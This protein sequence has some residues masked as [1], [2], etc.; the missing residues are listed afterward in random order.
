M[1]TKIEKHNKIDLLKTEFKA[2]LGKIE[3][4]Q[5]WLKA[6]ML[7]VLGLLIKIAFFS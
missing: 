7:G 6:A 1:A 3:V 4:E 5:R 2:S